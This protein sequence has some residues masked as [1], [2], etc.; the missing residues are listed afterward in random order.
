MPKGNVYQTIV[1]EILSVMMPRVLYSVVFYLQIIEIFQ[2]LTI[3][4]RISIRN[5]AFGA[6][7]R[8][9]TP[10]I[11]PEATANCMRQIIIA[12]VVTSCCSLREYDPF[13]LLF[14][15]FD[16]LLKSLMVRRL[17]RFVCEMHWK[18]ICFGYSLGKW[19][20]DYLLHTKMLLRSKLQAHKVC[21]Y[22][23]CSCFRDSILNQVYPAINDGTNVNYCY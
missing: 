20:T 12:I 16:F 8:T 10:I 22:F 13:R 17:I 6:L 18:Q 11:K 23:I 1:S 21:T 9:L 19:S 14:T 3:M 2:N 4:L 15:S 7:R 5:T